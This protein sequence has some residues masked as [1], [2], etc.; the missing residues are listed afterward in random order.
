MRER[1]LRLAVVCYG[2]VSL[3]VYT[4]GVTKEIQKLVR[5][6]KILYGL[7]KSSRHETSY[8][9]ASDDG[10]RRETDTEA[11][12]FDLLETIA[13]KLELRVIVDVVA[14]ASAGGI[15]AVALSR[16][17]AHDL[18]LDTHRD[19]W[20]R[21]ADVAELMDSRN[22]PKAWTKW[23]MAPLI[24]RWSKHTLRRLLSDPESRRK[25]SMLVR[26]PWFQPPFSGR[27][28]SHVLLN[29]MGEMGLQCDPS[30][31]LLPVGHKLECLVSVTDFFGYPQALPINDPPIVYEL[32][33]R[34]TWRF[35]HL[36]TPAGEQISDLQA[37]NIPGLVLAQR[38]SSSYAGAF[39]PVQLKEIDEVLKERGETWPARSSFLERNLSSLTNAG[40][41][42]ND[43]Y[44]IDG[45]IVNNKPFAQT[46]L[47]LRSRPAHRQVD[48]RVIYIEPHPKT[49]IV[50]ATGSAPGFFR[51]L[52]AALS[53]IPRNEPISDDLAW[54]ADFSARIQNVKG[55][56]EANR[57][58]ISA[59]IEKLIGPEESYRLC[60]QE[61]AELRDQANSVAADEAGYTYATYV[62]L[63]VSGLLDGIADLLIRLCRCTPHLQAKLELR[64]AL[65]EWACERGLLASWDRNT[66]AESID[67]LRRFDLGF[68]MRRLRF[69]IRALNDLY[70]ASWVDDE[71]GK[72]LDH[73]KAQTYAQLGELSE[74]LRV[75]FYSPAF[76]DSVRRLLADQKPVRLNL[77]KVLD[78][79]AA[80]LDLA[81]LNKDSDGVVADFG[82]Q[83]DTLQLRR[84]VV[85]AY[86]GF[87]FF[88]VATYP[89]L[90]DR[91][92]H[93][94][95]V[96]KVDRISPDDAQSIRAGGA[97][98]TL[99]GIEL[100]H[101]GAFF[102]RTYRE[103]DYLWGRLHAADRL[104]DIVLSAVPEAQP[105][106]GLSFKVKLF[107]AILQSEK[108][109]LIHSA[110]LLAQLGR[111]IA[112]LQTPD[113]P[114]HGDR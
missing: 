36:Q 48:R 63:K 68:R 92:P 107:Q 21:Y 51:T 72:T 114:T 106:D 26:S 62:R 65:E 93:E 88:D 71:M 2:G 9:A 35:I 79:L 90:Q 94:L 109:H 20:L 14:G 4:H 87:P 29:A 7:D 44:F 49:G 112:A 52:R 17:L 77:V 66:N 53:E 5:A 8:A 13:R 45:S 11:V 47:A 104:V 67:F 83:I 46:I 41:D 39:P 40:L 108:P 27:R 59:C 37:E 78:R 43:A 102:S 57:S 84:E 103:N 31:S 64:A 74:R 1:E 97:A 101:F 22:H 91:D 81:A 28:L 75:S 98:A 42:P 10:S 24:Q 55:I 105:I 61:I 3:A 110:E 70:L 58:H 30:Q 73:C 60:A 56:V 25:F 54:L 50:S 18:P 100:G 23:Y 89:L 86:L 99:K 33:H 96:V 76:G 111:E 15:N 85:T 12:Y 69:L 95:E 34:H 19:M 38:A 16:A 80:E 32:E 113:S 6:S 82:K